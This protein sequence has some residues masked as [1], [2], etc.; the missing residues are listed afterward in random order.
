VKIKRWFR[1]VFRGW[2]PAEPL[3]S[4]HWLKNKTRLLGLSVIVASVITLGILSLVASQQTMIP[5]PIFTGEYDPGVYVGDY[6]T[7]GN[8]VCNL[9][10]P[11]DHFCIKDLA[12]KKMEVNAV[13]G[14]EVTLLYTERFKN[15]SATWRDG[16]TSTWDVEKADWSDDPTKY[17]ID[18]DQIIAANITEGIC[19]RS[20]CD[21]PE[22]EGV[23]TEVRTYLGVDRNVVIYSRR[24]RIDFDGKETWIR[25]SI[26]YDQESGIR[27]EFERVTWDGDIIQSMSAVETNI[28]STP[29]AFLSSFQEDTVAEIP[30]VALYSTTGSIIIAIFVG[31]GIIVRRKRSR[32]GEN[33]NEQ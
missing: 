27:L 25:D 15:D 26:V 33:D 32:G 7:Y 2:V 12:F 8:F 10:H 18:F 30:S 6:V 23:K 24:G 9:E 11:I 17:G 21:D 14:K 3:T 28:F 29:N 20:G 4:K 5:P 13:S 31:M 22:C 1:H 19:R 16:L